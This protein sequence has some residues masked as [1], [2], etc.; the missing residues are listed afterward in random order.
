M[1][2]QQK[3]VLESMHHRGNDCVAIRFPHQAELAK[4][5]RQI[6]DVLFSITNK[7]W[8]VPQR[9]DSV[10]LILKIVQPHHVAVDFSAFES[11]N[12]IN[13]TGQF[14]YEDQLRALR[15]MEQ[16]LNLKGY[17]KLTLKTYLSQF[18]LFLRFYNDYNP[19]DLT[20]TEIRNYLLYLVEKKKVSR[21]TQ[22]QAINSIKF[23]YEMVLLQDRKVYYLERPLKERRLPQVLSQEDIA[24]L[25]SVIENMKHRAMLM[26]IYSAGLRR[27]EL[28]RMRV[29]DVDFNRCVV[30][31]KGAKGRKDRQS[32]LAKS[33]EPF[34]KRYMEDYKPKYWMFEGAD[35]GQYGE[36]SIARVLEI[37]LQKAGINKEVTLHT[38]RHSF[39]THL[40]EGG[41]ATRYIQE[42]L[43]HE[44]AL[45]TEIYT[46]VSRSAL[47]RIQSPLDQISSM[48]FLEKGGKEKG[49]S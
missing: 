12:D 25:F 24:L 6:P 47:N 34:L 45:T 41:T 20:E 14:T 31:I 38:L 11:K 48:G 10:D 42:L 29:C 39:A 49:S 22:N 30:F 18:G 4:I 27:G 5:V 35:G 44:S 43:G 7:C 16:K 26:L 28:L 46:H 19:T 37:A 32:L 13:E 9:D 21:S 23:F 36:R 33:I 15:M 3:I 1:E 8:Y 40:L 2:S 17:S